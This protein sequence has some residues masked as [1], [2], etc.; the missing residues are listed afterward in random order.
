MYTYIY[1]HVHIH[2]HILDLSGSRSIAWP[3]LLLQDALKTKPEAL[4]LIWDSLNKDTSYSRCLKHPH[5]LQMS[6]EIVSFALDPST[7][8]A[9]CIPYSNPDQILRR[10]I[11]DTL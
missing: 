8:F 5:S 11:I 6:K 4:S 3:F 9:S 7:L 10:T 2:V 1:T